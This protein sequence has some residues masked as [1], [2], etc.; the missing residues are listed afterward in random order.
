MSSGQIA[1]LGAIAG[2]TI[3]LGLPLGR[4][5]PMPRVKTALNAV[6]I[7]ILLFLLWDVL[8]H[9]WQPVDEALGKHE[10][11]S[12]VGK[13]L[14]LAA[15]LGVGLLGLVWFDRAPKGALKAAPKSP[16]RQP[17]RSGP[18]AATVAELAPSHLHTGASRLALM[19]A[20]GIGLHNFAEGLAIGNSAAAGDLTLALMLVIGFGLHNATEGFGIVAPLTGQRPSWAFLAVLGLIGGSPTF[21]GTLVGQHFTNDLVSIAFLGLAAGSILYVVI[22][23]LAVAR[24]ADL[25]TITT[26]GIFVGL[27]LG[28]ATDAIITAA[29]A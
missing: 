3:F 29:G 11:G 4:L 16:D 8:S 9:A 6:A 24:K 27:V 19:I 2:F 22:E 12:A 1:V 23:L 15:T 21:L 26:W 20:T 10:I 13:G 7:G 5:K 28:F 14:V 17:V 25:K 18:G